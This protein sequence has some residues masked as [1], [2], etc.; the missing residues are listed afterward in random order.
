MNIN[1]YEE[2]KNRYCKG[3]S[4]IQGARWRCSLLDSTY[5]PDYVLHTLWSDLYTY[6]VTGTGYTPGG[7]DI[8]PVSI[9]QIPQENAPTLWVVKVREAYW[10]DVVL[11]ARYGV[12]YQDMGSMDRSPLVACIDFEEEIVKLHE[13]LTIQWTDDIFMQ[14]YFV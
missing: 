9:Q 5:V 1:L 13:P 12:V 11:T 4:V 3:I 2:Y 7:A 14:V 6:E 8:G 10:P